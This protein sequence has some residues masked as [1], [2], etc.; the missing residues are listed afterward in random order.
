M[1]KVRINKYNAW[2]FVKYIIRPFWTYCINY[3]TKS[4]LYNQQG[5]KSFYFIPSSE[6][7]AYLKQIKVILSAV[8]KYHDEYEIWTE[9]VSSI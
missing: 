3:F 9:A 2:V 7:N 4:F 5:S 1:Y 8:K 6:F